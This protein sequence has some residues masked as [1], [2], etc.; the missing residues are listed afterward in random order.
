M[1]KGGAPIMKYKVGMYGGSFDPLHLGHIH[2]IIRASSE[3]ETLYIML[4]WSAKRDSVP[5]EL[6]YRWLLE[7]TKHL[8]NIKI[9]L[10]ED[11]AATKEEYNSDYYWENGAQDIK[12]LIGKPIDAVFCGDDYFQSG[13]FESLY[14]E[15]K[16][17]YYRRAEVPI[18]STEIRNNC[19]DYQWDYIPRV[20]QPYYVKKILIVGGESTGKST[21]VRN[22]ALAY[23]TTY[24][25]EYGRFTCERAGG[26][27][28]MT[29][30][31][32]VENLLYQKTHELEALQSANK[33][34]FIDTDAVT[35]KFYA[36]L[37][38]TDG[39]KCS[40]LADAIASI[41]KYDLILFLEPTVVFVQDG[42]R[43]EEI[44]ANREKYS[45]QLKELF[46]QA[47]MEV[48]SI[49]GDYKNRFNSAKN[50]IYKHFKISTDW[51]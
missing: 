21:L 5:K 17:I 30:D 26:E 3:C 15:S 31:D 4:S 29:E 13:R 46:M 43:N 1:G 37:L 44:A 33:L 47:D 25:E 42:T 20:A 27:D 36:S 6:R 39:N 51:R 22:L 7:V 12:N 19:T 35:T 10:V 40:K 34:L 14:P 8:P 23:N 24:V 18:S 28:F 9:M 50:L 48:H 11:K 38:L 49:T 45:Q 32:L 41:N 2:D 16:V